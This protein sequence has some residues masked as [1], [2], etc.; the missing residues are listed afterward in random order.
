MS[1]LPVMYNASTPPG[2]Q[3]AHCRFLS[4]IKVSGIDLPLPPKKVFGNMDAAFI[5]ERQQGLQV[6][7]MYLFP[8]VILCLEQFSCLVILSHSHSFLVFFFSHFKTLLNVHNSNYIVIE[9]SISVIC[10]LGSK[11][12]QAVG[13]TL[14][15][16][17]T[18]HD[19]YMEVVCFYSKIKKKKNQPQAE[20]DSCWLIFFFRII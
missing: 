13:D 9:S 19:L 5:A 4:F 20:F 8:S 18:Y 2:M 16:I 12:L 17:K 14:P 10:D 15:S 7:Y 1:D 3:H 6:W 11:L